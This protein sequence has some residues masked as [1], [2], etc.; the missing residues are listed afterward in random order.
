MIPILGTLFWG[1]AETYA[2]LGRYTERFKNSKMVKSIFEEN[3][4][5]IQYL[6]Y[7]YGCASGIKG[8]KI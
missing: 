6:S 3:G 1:K 7:F 4:F 5:D 8:R 2:M